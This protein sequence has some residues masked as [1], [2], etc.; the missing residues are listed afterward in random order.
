MQLQV[1]A[2]TC[3]SSGETPLT[4]EYHQNHLKSKVVEPN[5]HFVPFFDQNRAK[6]PKL[7]IQDMKQVKKVVKIARR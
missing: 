2:E 3:I 6:F 4:V 1:L 5:P 7:D